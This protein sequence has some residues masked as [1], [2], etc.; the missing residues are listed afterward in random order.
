MALVFIIP[1]EA[2]FWLGV[3]IDSPSSNLVLRGFISPFILYE[4]R[5]EIRRCLKGGSLFRVFL[6]RP[7]PANFPDSAGRAQLTDAPFSGSI[8]RVPVRARSPPEMG[9]DAP[10]CAPPGLRSRMVRR[11]TFGTAQGPPIRRL[12]RGT[13]D[14]STGTFATAI[15]GICPLR[16]CALGGLIGAGC[17]RGTLQTAGRS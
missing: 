4:R 14:T 3:L 6:N 11:W 5:E 9:V 12:H 17:A 15:G 16:T 7:S 10:L 2:A 13:I 8:C 1:S